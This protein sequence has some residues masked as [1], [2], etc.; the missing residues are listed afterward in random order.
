MKSH[1]V[2]AEEFHRARKRASFQELLARL[3]R[4]SVELLSYEEVRQKLRASG[5]ASQSIREVP[6]DAILGSVGRYT[7]FTRSF[8]PRRTSDR[9]RWVRIMV[10]TNDTS[11]L[12]PVDLYLIDE[13]YFVSDGHHRVSV[14]REVGAETIQAY[15]TEIR[16]DIPLSADDRREDLILKAEYADFLN[17]TQITASRPNA[18]LAVST[19]GQYGKLLDHISVHR[20]FLGIDLEREVSSAESVTHWYDTV[21]LPV[22]LIVRDLGI[23]HDFPQRTEADLY[24]WISHHRAEIAEAINWEVDYEAAAADLVAQK[25]PRWRRIMSRLGRSVIDI[26][27]PEGYASTSEVTELHYVKQNAPERRRLFNDIL[28]PV[29]G[30]EVGWIALDQALNVATLEG[31]RVLGLHVVTGDDEPESQL[32]SMEDGFYWRCGEKGVQGTMAFAKGTIAQTICERAR[33]TDLVVVKLLYP[34]GSSALERYSSGLVKM[35]RSCSR[36]ILVVAGEVS[37]LN[38]PLLIWEDNDK[39]NLALMVAAYVAGQWKLPIVVLA[40]N[41][42]STQAPESMETLHDY[43]VEFDLEATYLSGDTGLTDKILNIAD[44][45]SCDWIVTGGYD[46]SALK[47]ILVGT[48]LD[49]LL[50][51]SNIPILICQ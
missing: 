50:G 7:D 13:V 49:E 1:Y 16:S 36:P 44:E 10:A 27:S 46:S 18:D 39:S 42:S 2:A 20:Y 9:E 41:D 19:A 23:L 21:Y 29:S 45:R 48:S 3:T 6:L 35:I 40:C 4:Q 12:P 43:L 11:G 26:V 14:A 38:K 33:W 22:V 51:Q 25:G 32:K 15:V 8:L 37:S 17:Q 47:E 34:P 28:V 30:L 31:G 24:L 5:V